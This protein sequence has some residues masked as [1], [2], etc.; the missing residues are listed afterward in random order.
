LPFC[1]IPRPKNAH[2][3]PFFSLFS[4]T[5]KKSQKRDDYTNEQLGAFFA[6]QKTQACRGFRRLRMNVFIMSADYA[7]PVQL[8]PLP[9]K[10]TQFADYSASAQK[11]SIQ[12]Q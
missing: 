12:N 1:F 6:S 8:T 2:F 11:V 4:K 10:P 5:L 3:L 9:R 7:R